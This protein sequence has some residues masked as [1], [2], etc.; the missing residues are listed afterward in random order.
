MLIVSLVF[1]VSLFRPS[2][3]CST[4]LYSV[5]TLCLRYPLAP[6]PRVRR[7]LYPVSDY[8]CYRNRC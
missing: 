4:L 3:R 1:R 6:A 5:V 7:G 2:V 8:I